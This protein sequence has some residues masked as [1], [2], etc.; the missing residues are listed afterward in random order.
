[1]M[2]LEVDEW[3]ADH[4]TT[5]STGYRMTDAERAEALRLL[6]GAADLV[7]QIPPEIAAGI[8]QAILRL[9]GGS[10]MW[11]RLLRHIDEE[12]RG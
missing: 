6:S 12:A 9:D 3:A 2:L 10:L 11:L 7:G 4:P 1:M 8:K 5:M